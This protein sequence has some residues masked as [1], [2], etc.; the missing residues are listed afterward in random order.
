MNQVDAPRA[1]I[2]I[3]DLM[4]ETLPQVR[5]ALALLESAGH[6]G[7]TLLVVPGT[8][9]DSRGIAELR[10]LERAG[11]QL[12]GHGWR[13]QVD[14]IQG[15]YHRLHAGLISRN[16]AEHLALDR[17]GIIAMINRCWNWFG[18]QGLNEP[19]L[20]VPPA[21]AMGGITRE[22]LATHCPFPAYEVLTG[23]IDARQASNS[24]FIPLP[25]LGYEADQ[26]ARLP[27]I[28]AWNALNRRWARQRGQLRIGI[29]PK[30]PDLLMGS[31]LRRDLLAYPQSTDYSALLATSA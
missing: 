27:A 2:S 16:V 9:W 7:I 17:N 12:A 6:S 26:R 30:D 10:A 19:S 13:H 23:V 22:A 15:L 18:D 20:Y 31:D 21:W 5:R 1:L 29:H 14:H 25:M 8:G 11:H 4:P 28:R 3:H 24:R